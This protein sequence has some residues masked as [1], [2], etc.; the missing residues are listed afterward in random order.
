MGR[1]QNLSGKVVWEEQNIY[2]E[3]APQAR[4]IRYLL[5]TVENGINVAVDIDTIDDL[6][7]IGN[8]SAAGAS[9]GD[10]LTYM[11]GT[12]QDSDPQTWFDSYIT[13]THPTYDIPPEIA[14]LNDIPNVSVSTPADGEVLTYSDTLSQWVSAPVTTSGGGGG[15]GGTEYFAGAGLSLLNGNTFL[16]GGS[17]IA[18]N[19]ALEP[20]LSG[21]WDLALGSS[22][23]KWDGLSIAAS[24]ITMQELTN[25]NISAGTAPGD[26]SKL[27][28]TS[29]S[30][31]L[32]YYH[33]TFTNESSILLGQTAM[34][35]TDNTNNQGLV[36]AA[37]Y[38][39][40][41]TSRSLVDKA[42]VDAE[43]IAASIG[44]GGGATELDGL[45]DVTSS[46]ETEGQI[47]AYIGGAWINVNGQTWA[48]NN[49][50]LDKS[51][52]D[53]TDVT[54]TSAAPL[55]FVIYNGFSWVNNTYASILSNIQSDTDL[56]ELA[57]VDD[58]GVV[59]GDLIVY[60][61]TSSSYE[62]ASA[63]PASRTRTITVANS[64]QSIPANRLIMAGGGADTTHTNYIKAVQAQ[65]GIL[66]TAIIGFSPDNG[67][68]IFDI[69]TEGI[70]AVPTSA[71]SGTVPGISDPVFHSAVATGRITGDIGGAFVGYVVGQDGTDLLV[72]FRL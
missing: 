29:T 70:V 26:Q 50:N 17:D 19:L 69:V 8:I 10:I 37:D 39:T 54:I 45:S 31:K 72:D 65:V 27:D 20:A 28:M 13:V 67:T 56:G 33:T 47:L 55:D 62:V 18:G 53:L 48:D 24:A 38:A 1:R 40:N 34:T 42:Y 7:E 68:G 66:I 57:N 22:I 43:I 12:W 30:A 49:L 23:K 32:G 71:F 44:G 64:A 41:Y 25:L 6:S 60:N 46:N 15:G 51:F 58:T 36:Y 61:G 5:D 59:D 11:S 3:D 14:V 16:L 4:V 35:V 63:A 2:F 9:N 21:Q 52:D